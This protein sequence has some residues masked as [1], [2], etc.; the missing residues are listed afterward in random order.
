ME[1][2][3]LR[4]VSEKINIS[5][6]KVHAAL[7]RKNGLDLPITKIGKKF[8]FNSEEVEKARIYFE[9]RLSAKAEIVKLNNKLKAKK[10]EYY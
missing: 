3:D 4:M 1:L 8:L 7:C 9:N 6:A 2:F 5:Y 10:Q